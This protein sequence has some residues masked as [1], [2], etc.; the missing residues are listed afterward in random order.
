MA[1]DAEQVLKAWLCAECYGKGIWIN[2]ENGILSKLDT[3]HTRN[4]Q[5]T[6]RIVVE[7]GPETT[8]AE[9]I[10]KRNYSKATHYLQ[11]FFEPHGVSYDGFNPVYQSY[12]GG[13]GGE[14]T[15]CWGEIKDDYAGSIDVTNAFTNS[16]LY[17]ADLRN[18]ILVMYSEKG[19]YSHGSSGASKI[20]Q[21]LAYAAWDGLP[22]S[23]C[24]T[25]SVNDAIKLAVNFIA[26]LVQVETIAPSLTPYTKTD[27]IANVSNGIAVSDYSGYCGGVAQSGCYSFPN[28]ALIDEAKPY[29]CAEGSYSEWVLPE[30]IDGYF[31]SWD[32]NGSGVFKPIDDYDAER[33]ELVFDYYNTLKDG[34]YDYPNFINISGVPHGSWAVSGNDKKFYSQQNRD[35]T[36]FAK[37]DGED[38]ETK[39][40]EFAD[41]TTKTYTT[42][43]PVAPV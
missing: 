41:D 29:N 39:V 1:T 42:Y 32:T 13:L 34:T 43:F 21:H 7:D 36:Y 2:W 26:N 40:K 9:P 15:S 25:I 16:E 12:F 37:L 33:F 35:G 30:G 11:D 6:L 18:D 27:V 28:Y 20:G 10:L 31:N 4:T 5:L 24:R 19:D 23:S 38:P 3:Q 8:V 14:N 22:F 17:F